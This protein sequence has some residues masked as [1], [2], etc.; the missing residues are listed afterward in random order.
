M[1]F[2]FG[3]LVSSN[4]AAG[5][6]SQYNSIL[7]NQLQQK[8]RQ[9]EH[10]ASMDDFE[11]GYE[12]VLEGDIKKAIRLWEKEAQTGVV[13]A[14][15]A[16]GDLYHYRLKNL[17]KATFHYQKAYKSGETKAGALILAAKLSLGKL[18][19]RDLEDTP[20]DIKDEPW[21]KYVKVS[22]SLKKTTYIDL[23]LDDE[24]SKKSQEI[25]SELVAAINGGVL[26]AGTLFSKLFSIYSY[27]SLYLNREPALT[28]DSGEYFLEVVQHC[29]ENGD[30]YA[31]EI[32][33]LWLLVNK[34]Y[35]DAMNLIDTFDS[36]FEWPENRSYD[37]FGLCKGLL[38]LPNH[39]KSATKKLFGVTKS[40]SS[41]FGSSVFDSFTSDW[42]KW[43]RFKRRYEILQPKGEEVSKFLSTVE[44][45]GVIEARRVLSLNLVYR[46]FEQESGVFGDDSD[47]DLL[48]LYFF[49]ALSQLCIA[50]WELA[51]EKKKADLQYVPFIPILKDFISAYLVGSDEFETKWN[52]K[53][54]N[55]GNTKKHNFYETVLPQLIQK[56]EVL[57]S[58]RSF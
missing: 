53:D 42:E 3:Y 56:F 49:L 21:F 12:A 37:V 6:V 43:E 34:K 55:L 23:L 39:D 19:E 5:Y 24:D 50:G 57:K 22:L 30:S 58:N 51:A 48:H 18:N 4:P 29:A 16:L 26:P 13:E 20:Q 33:L 54:F 52:L 41:A 46:A 8:I 44:Q 25:T 35:P 17:Q 27:L 47:S 10:E 1:S 45:Y 14:H 40:I 36:Q 9:L 15:V 28:S 38:T 2:D 11:K 7:L 32:Y 31:A